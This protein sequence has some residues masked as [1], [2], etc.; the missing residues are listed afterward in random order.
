MSAPS[1]HGLPQS[2]SLRGIK[3]VGTFSQNILVFF[4]FESLQMLDLDPIPA[5]SIVLWFKDV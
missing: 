4:S 2:I 3:E 1:Y 5:V